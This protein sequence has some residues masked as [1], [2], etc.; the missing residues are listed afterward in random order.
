MKV[1]P[2]EQIGSGV[3]EVIVGGGPW[4]LEEE[5]AI[6]QTDKQVARRMAARRLHRAYPSDVS[7]FRAVSAS[8]CTGR[9]DQRTEWNIRHCRHSR[10]RM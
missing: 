10:A 4:L 3:I 1:I 7:R 6:A 8:R 2:F 5:Q 9:D